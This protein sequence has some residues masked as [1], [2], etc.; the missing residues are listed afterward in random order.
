MFSAGIGAAE[1]AVE[2]LVAHSEK[3]GMIKVRGEGRKGGVRSDRPCGSISHH[4]PLPLALVP[5]DA[6]GC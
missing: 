6:F 2:H 1:E 4:P 5:I 3:V